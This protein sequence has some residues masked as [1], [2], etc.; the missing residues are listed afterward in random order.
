M[1]QLNAAPSLE[2]PCRPCQDGWHMDCAR[3]IQLPYDL[4]PRIVISCCC[5][6]LDRDPDP[7]R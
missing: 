7:P 1:T 5:D 4:S 2:R 6:G 3:W